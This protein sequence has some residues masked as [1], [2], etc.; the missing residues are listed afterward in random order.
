MLASFV[1]VF[2]AENW[3]LA[4]WTTSFVDVLREAFGKDLP[5]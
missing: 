5:L 3:F 1:C 4:I 2:E